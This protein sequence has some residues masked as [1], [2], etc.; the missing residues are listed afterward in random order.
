MKCPVWSLSSPV[1]GSSDAVI[2]TV[3]LTMFVSQFSGGWGVITN[4]MTATIP[5]PEKHSYAHNWG[6]LLH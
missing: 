3:V 6:I 2:S 1:C 4:R 5:C